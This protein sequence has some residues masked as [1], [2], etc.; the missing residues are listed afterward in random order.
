MFSYDFHLSNEESTASNLTFDEYKTQCLRHR[1]YLFLF[2][3]GPVLLLP[4]TGLLFL[5]F[6]SE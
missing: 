5:P 2:Q 6:Q 3:F 1:R 4:Q